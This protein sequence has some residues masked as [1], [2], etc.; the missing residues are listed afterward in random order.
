MDDTDMTDVGYDIDIDVGP[1]VEAPAQ[2]G[3]QQVIEVSS[4]H[5]Y[6]SFGAID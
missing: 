4:T 2:P 6:T 3:Q 1:G 5:G